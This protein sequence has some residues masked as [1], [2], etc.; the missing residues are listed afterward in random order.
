M[1]M[2]FFIWPSSA[3]QGRLARVPSCTRLPMYLPEIQIAGAAVDPASFSC[4]LNWSKDAILKLTPRSSSLSAAARENGQPGYVKTTTPDEVRVS[5]SVASVPGSSAVCSALPFCTSSCFGL[6]NNNV[7]LPRITPSWTPN[8]LPNVAARLA[9]DISSCS[10]VK[11]AAGKPSFP[12]K[13][14]I[15][16][17]N[18]TPHESLQN[19]PIAAAVIEEMPRVAP[20]TA[21]IVDP[22]CVITTQSTTPNPIIGTAFCKAWARNCW[23]EG[24]PDEIPEN[25]AAAGGRAA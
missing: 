6:C 17:P 5:N 1:Q 21:S 13:D 20:R 15:V 3:H 7:E 9:S 19:K 24:V 18:R 8:N 23:G 2:P 22:T 4:D 11:W 10:V 12:A 14:S 25:P 16:P